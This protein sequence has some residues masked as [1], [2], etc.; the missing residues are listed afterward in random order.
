MNNKEKNNSENINEL[1]NEINTKTK[2]DS[3]DNKTLITPENNLEQNNETDKLS[4][5]LKNLLLLD[6][7]FAKP[8]TIEKENKLFTD[9]HYATFKNSYAENTC[10]INVILHLLYNI[11]Q[12]EDFLETLYNID[13]SNKISNFS[14]LRNNKTQIEET[15]DT[16][17]FLVLIGK[18]LSE[19]KEIINNENDK[20]IFRKIYN[21]NKQVFVINTLRMR[22][23]LEKVSKGQFA[24]N[25]I[26][27]PVEFFGFILDI[28]NEYSNED[29]HKTFY[30]ELIDEYICDKN[31]CTQIN[32]KYDKDNFMYHIYI[33]EILKFIEKENLK[34]YNFKN[35]LFEFSH[36]LFISEN[37]K[38]C[39]KCK[40]K[41]KHNLICKN[42]PDFILINCVWRESNPIL[43]DAMTLFFMMPLRDEFSNL[44]IHKTKSYRKNFYY[45]FGF[46]LYSFTLSHYIICI[47]NYDKKVFV[48]LND[49]IV[50]E[51]HNL[52]ELLLDIT[53]DTLKDTGKAFFYPVMLIYT[54]DV[55]YD[56]QVM[57]VNTLNNSEYQ[58]II[59]KCN[60]AIYQFEMESKI[61]EEEKSNNYKEFIQKQ[62]EIEEEII[63]NSLK[64]SKYESYRKS[65]NIKNIEIQ[66]EEKKE[67]KELKQKINFD[68]ETETKINNNIINEIKEENN[69]ENNNNN[70]N[71]IKEENYI[72]NNNIINSKIKKENNIENNNNIIN[73][74]KE[75]NYIKNNNIINSEIKKENNNNINNEIKEEKNLV[76]NNN[77]IKKRLEEKNMSTIGRILKDMK[78]IKGNNLSDFYFGD[79]LKSRE[80][81]IKDITT[82]VR[83]N[84]KLLNNDKE[85]NIIG[86][87]NNKFRNNYLYKSNII[88]NNNN[89]NRT[90]RENNKMSVI[91]TKEEEM[92][93]NKYNNKIKENN[94]NYNSTAI[95][96]IKSKRFHRKTN[97]D[98]SNNN[99][100]KN[101]SDLYRNRNLYSNINAN[102]GTQINPRYHYY[103]RVKKNQ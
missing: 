80:N 27:D 65:K 36:N 79:L 69:K 26:A 38:T 82:R 37:T 68:E 21:K 92:T 30:L 40:E 9:F 101:T 12:L 70:K 20:S 89:I 78:E 22:K 88:W 11:E 53:V 16:Y 77:D 59:N 45:L 90:T 72:K 35:K 73:E 44:F 15:N 64:K 5:S 3:N 51:F 2:N 99:N 49:E 31:G 17:T 48:L 93:N 57:K 61:K 43:D 47:Y 56:S 60:E 86:D 42:L 6:K 25:T 52:Y 62:K 76:N 29:I 98:I 41:M 28:L 83:E 91:E 54:N 102:N 58:D 14:R 71:E 46:I 10:Y 95:N 66:P 100:N 23:M 84:E 103:N 81:N 85:T 24:L 33:D 32:N 4:Q 1:N 8:V 50:K 74:I 18:I 87:N 7:D 39:E 13:E 75:E 19:Y 67:N 55:L 94:L 34:V 63:R 96:S 97:T